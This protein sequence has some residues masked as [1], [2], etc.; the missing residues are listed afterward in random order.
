M[1]PSAT[2]DRPTPTGA[3]GEVRTDLPDADG[4]PRVVV[5]PA[6]RLDATLAATP[7]VEPAPPIVVLGDPD[8][9]APTV[10]PRVHYVLR[11][12]APPE[13]LRA[14]LAALAGP[15][16]RER[17]TLPPPRTTPEA[18]TLEHAFVASRRLAAATD[19][20]AAEAVLIESTLELA[21]A[22]RARC[23][24]HDADDGALW[25]ELTTDDAPR[26]AVAGLVGFAARTGVGVNVARAAADPRWSRAIDGPDG[27]RDHLLVWPVLDSDGASQAVLVAARDERRPAFDD[28]ACAALARLCDLAAPLLTQLEARALAQAVLARAPAAQLFRREAVEARQPARWGDVVRVAPAWLPAAYWLMVG[29]LLASVAYLA[30]SRVSTYSSGPAVVRAATRRDASARLAGTVLAVERG[31][32]DRV[33]AGAVLARLDD[34]AQRAA[35]E[36][37]TRAFE[38]QL[39]GHLLDPGD[40]D[41]TAAL[42]RLRVELDAARD[43]LEDRLVRSPIAGQVAE[44]RAH[45]GQRVEP[46]DVV[47]SLVDGEGALEVIALLP[48]EDRPRLAP[49]MELRLELDGYPYSHESIA[50]D[51]VSA[52]VIAPAEALRVMGAELGDGLRLGGPVV[53]ARGRLAAPELV[54]DGRRLLLHD[55]MRG[56]AEVRIDEQR[57]LFALIPGARRL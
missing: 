27:P 33:E 30:L 41:D 53:L 22:D 28:A 50:I 49:G 48:G 18:R 13:H 23:F 47:A 35:V 4:G 10:A 9:L 39:R 29:L 54:F 46:G 12:E 11:P 34:A 24:F 40:E 7:S 26:R 21:D 44:L 6:D 20:A 42:Q 8:A 16:S 31:V 36:R 52:A 55:G 51:S 14:L 43:A 57:A 2:L 17:P 45:P 5:C 15:R 56:V 37:L 19:L 25:S 32:G 1:D 3:E 38:A